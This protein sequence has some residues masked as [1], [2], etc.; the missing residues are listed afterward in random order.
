M[1]IR[2]DDTVQRH[3]ERD[4][5]KEIFTGAS[6]RVPFTV[7]YFTQPSIEVQENSA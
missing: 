3:K 2:D 5:I 4:A 1:V 7:H 6:P